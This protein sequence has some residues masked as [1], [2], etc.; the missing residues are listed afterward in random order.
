MS[1]KHQTD[2]FSSAAIHAI[3]WFPGRLLGLI[4]L[5]FTA[6]AV[7]EETDRSD[8]DAFK[9][10]FGEGAQEEDF[11]QANRLLS[12]ATRRS[13]PIRKA[14]AIATIID[15][16]EIRDMGA[17][18]FLDVIKMVPGFGVSV[19]ERGAWQI[20]VRGISSPFSEK[21]L[22][23]IDG[24]AVNKNFVG[25]AFYYLYHDMPVEFIDH[26]EVVRG[27]GSALYGS[28]A[29]VAV[30]NVVTRK[31][32]DAEGVEIKASVGSYDDY[33][34]NGMYG[35]IFDNGLQL[36]VNG[37][38]ASKGD[39]DITIE[40]DCLS[41]G[42]C[43]N[44]LFAGSSL[45][46]GKADT[47]SKKRNLFVQMD[48]D[49]W[50]FKGELLRTRPGSYIGFGYALAQDKP[51][52]VVDN[53]WG[54]LS[55]HHYFSDDLGVSLRGYYDYFEQDADIN[56][57]PPD[58]LVPGAYTNG[59]PKLKNHTYG[60][61]LQADYD[62]HPD[63]HLILGALYEYKRQTDVSH[64]NNF[65]AP[66]FNRNINQDLYAL[67]LQEEWS[68]S[69]SLNLTFGA[70]YDH[71][72][73]F[74]GTLNP[75][76]GLVWSVAPGTDLKLLYG[77]AFRAPNNVELYNAGNP[78]VVG[79][80]ELQPE[81]IKT[82]ELGISHRFNRI[83][84]I[85]VSIYHSRFSQIINIVPPTA[86]LYT[87]AGGAKVN[88]TEWVFDARI[89]SADDLRLSYIYQDP[90]D[91]ETDERL[92]GVPRQRVALNLN[93]AFNSIWTLHSDL[94]WSGERARYD[95]DARSPVDAFTTV[96]LALTANGLVEG[97]VLQLSAH[98]LFDESYVDPDSSGAAALIPN[99]FP[100]EGRTFMLSAS[101]EF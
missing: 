78:S 40:D 32:L 41:S 100:R 39:S 5:L 83:F 27:P 96:D 76:A 9:D 85:E 95:G 8:I 101:Y 44:G 43:F 12:L 57:F 88:G 34:L 3:Q 49:E 11:Y 2:C 33:R 93:H 37:H 54:D 14:P 66:N 51:W 58:V 90:K 24:H 38:F 64:E 62:P 17:R 75:R 15:A 35:R 91:N 79:N 18:D 68:Y 31:A 46:P 52:G 28:N 99:D 63:H 53:I 6:A 4:F 59:K 60:L 45:A 69:E 80:P 26:L 47:E 86:P 29:M 87:N 22:L 55:Y 84:S 36:Y 89:S 97:L 23:M 74:G 71:Y 13:T 77:S 81:K 61:E 82:T 42:G 67:Y 70:R 10:M 19:N 25:S 65:G 56:L 21:V 48:Y 72:S 7:A 16:D 20:E 1:R 50:S 98:N 73:D 94:L 30:I 92:P